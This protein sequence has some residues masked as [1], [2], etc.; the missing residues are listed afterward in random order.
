MT[1]KIIIVIATIL[2]SGI[3]T[4]V[5]SQYTSSSDDKELI[6]MIS[7]LLLLENDYVLLDL[8]DQTKFRVETF[9]DTWDEK[10]HWY[11]TQIK[12]EIEGVF[13]TRSL[14]PLIS[15]GWLWLD[16]WLLFS[17]DLE[18]SE[19]DPYFWNGHLDAVSWIDAHISHNS[20]RYNNELVWK[21]IFE[22]RNL[23][24]DE[25]K[26]ESFEPNYSNYRDPM[27]PKYQK[28]FFNIQWLDP[29]TEYSI[30]L[31]T[32]ETKYWDVFHL[33]NQKHKTEDVELIFK[34]LPDWEW[35]YYSEE[36]IVFLLR[37]GDAGN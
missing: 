17:R 6:Q 36:D 37:I 18:L 12:N 14:F 4:F 28:V 22:L 25:T 26:I 24:S 15:N 7:W 3:S 23:D 29:E 33:T 31:L 27:Y 34:T 9:V 16:S 2:L 21:Y 10:K 13:F 8:F 35:K 1:K 19:Y 5:F 11:A 20:M 32:I 30:R